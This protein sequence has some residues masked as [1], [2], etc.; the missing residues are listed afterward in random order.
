MIYELTLLGK[1]L[2]Q[3]MLTVLHYDFG[4]GSEPN[5]QAVSDLI[6]E[7]MDTNLKAMLTPQSSYTGIRI[8]PDSPGAVGTEYPFSLGDLVG[9]G[10][11]SDNLNQAAVLVRKLTNSSVKPTRGRVYQGGISVGATEADGKWVGLVRTALLAFW[12]D[13]KLLVPV[14]GPNGQM[15][16]K[17]SK[18][19]APNTQPYTV[20]TGIQVEG[21]PVTQRRRRLGIGS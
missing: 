15:V 20:V 4:D 2:N 17:A 21:T 8:R 18:P 11:G 5:W 9:T 13:M 10:A 16:I 6:R 14:G 7:D 12:Q 3:D 19:T 1:Q